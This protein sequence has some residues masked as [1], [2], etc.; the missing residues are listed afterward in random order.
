[1]EI[2]AFYMIPIILWIVGS[3]LYSHEITLKE[4][5]LQFGATAAVVAITVVMSYTGAL[6][7]RGIVVGQ[8]VEKEIKTFLCDTSWSR[9]TSTGCE[10]YYTRTVPDGRSCHGS[11]KDRVCTTKYRTEYRHVYPWERNY[12]V[13]GKHRLVSD[14]AQ[15]ARIDNQGAHVPPRYDA[16]IIGEPFAISYSYNNYVRAAESSLFRKDETVIEGIAYPRITDYYRINGQ[17]A[18]NLDVKVLQ[19]ISRDS[20]VMVL[21]YRTDA[22]DRKVKDD[23]A[24]TLH[25]HKMYDLV[26]V[27]G[28]DWVEVSSWSKTSMVNVTTRDHIRDNPETWTDT[29]A[30]I[31][32]RDYDFPLEKDFEYLWAEVGFPMLGH[33]LLILILIIGVPATTYFLATNA[34]D[35]GG[36]IRRPNKGFRF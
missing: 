17:F 19:N 7:D 32:K 13:H 36:N 33:I 35:K 28:N 25:G 2:Y 15:I 14:T 22:S 29:V 8:V 12:Y 26:I 10:H 4:A 3:Y 6:R 1:M 11:G 21:Y 5:A 30:E 24:K 16:A 9:S 18:G 34:S 23:L 20:G 27:Q 31:I